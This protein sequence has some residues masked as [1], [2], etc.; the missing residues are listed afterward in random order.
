[1]K[2]CDWLNSKFPARVFTLTVQ[3]IAVNPMWDCFSGFEEKASQFTFAGLLD[4][5][6]LLTMAD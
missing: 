1:M 2:Q 4:S 5:L 6:D 3:F